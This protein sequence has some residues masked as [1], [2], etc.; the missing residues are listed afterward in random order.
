M[1]VA[2][3]VSLVAT[4]NSPEFALANSQLELRSLQRLA[5]SMP[6]EKLGATMTEKVE[7][8]AQKAELEALVRYLAKVQEVIAIGKG[9]E[10]DLRNMILVTEQA[11]VAGQALALL[12]EEVLCW[13][14]VG[15]NLAAATHRYVALK[16]QAG[17]LPAEVLG[18][19]R[20]AQERF[21][22][23]YRQMLAQLV[24][25]PN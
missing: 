23:H 10:R 11:V 4:V 1:I 16:V 24:A 14:R 9:E 19:T 20:A 25:N 22:R 12:P 3:V 21:K 6:A 17:M 15:L 8:Q 2:F 5:A 13:D 7:Y 18:E